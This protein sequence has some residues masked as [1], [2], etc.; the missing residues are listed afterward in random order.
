MDTPE[1]PTCQ[2]GMNWPSHQR[3][4]LIMLVEIVQRHKQDSVERASNTVTTGGGGSS[5]LFHPMDF[6]TLPSH[7]TCGVYVIWFRGLLRGF[8]MAY[9][10]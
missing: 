5:S 2:G 6:L 8:D 3:S 10:V 9:G 7:F 1:Y 4:P